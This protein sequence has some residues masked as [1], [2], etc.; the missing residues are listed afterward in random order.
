MFCYSQ[1]NEVDERKNCHLLDAVRTLL[2]ESSVPS[3]F[4]VEA[5]RIAT[6]LINH[7][8]SQVLHMEINMDS[9]V[10]R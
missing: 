5:L 3:M 10:V 8:P 1:Q 4:W 7:L 6:H 2:L 9:K